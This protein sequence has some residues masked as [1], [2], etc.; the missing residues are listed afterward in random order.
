VSANNKSK[1]RRMN[2]MSKMIMKEVQ[3]SM[4]DMF[5]QP[6]QHHHLDD[7]SDIHESHHVEAMENITVSECFNCLTCISHPIKRLKTQHFAPITTQLLEMHLGKSSIHILGVLFDSGSSGSI[8]VAKFIKKPYIQNDTKTEWF[9]KGGIFHTS[10][11]CKT[12][13][14]LNEFYESKFIEW[15]FDV[16]KTF[17]PHRYDMIIG[18]DL[19]SQLGI[20]LDFD[21]QPCY[22]V[23]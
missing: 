13:F 23:G 4:K 21:R 12:N 20:I 1:K 18:R 11:K 19:M 7:D 17:S 2:F 16:N 8:I 14:I 15:I 3:E 22:D 6:H 5:K 10:S 9:T